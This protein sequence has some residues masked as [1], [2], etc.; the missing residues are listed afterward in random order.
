MI[1]GIISDTHSLP[2]PVKVIEHF[3]TVDLIIHAGDI[4]D[5]QTIKL[6]KGLGPAFKA[7]QGNMDEPAL[8]KALPT[9]EIIDCQGTN[10]GVTHGHIGG[11]LNALSNAYTFFQGDKV[12]IVVFGHSHEAIKE[13]IGKT[14]YLNPGSPNDTVRAKFFSY[15]IIEINQ[16]KIKADIIKI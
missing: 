7:V 12:D 9:K 14:L 5:A 1:I 6:L 4:C 11:A 13:K 10:V 15:G 8:K 3:K 2:I 16:S